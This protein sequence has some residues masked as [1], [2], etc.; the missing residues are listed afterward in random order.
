MI[1]LESLEAQPE[2][3]LWVTTA[4]R[5]ALDLVAAKVIRF[6]NN[7]GIREVPDKMC[8]GPASAISASLK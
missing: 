8:P 1:K 6:G 5:M 4:S 2:P 3:V 7:V